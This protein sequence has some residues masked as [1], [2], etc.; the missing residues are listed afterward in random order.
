M[1]SIWNKSI[2][3]L[4]GGLA[5]LLAAF[6]LTGCITM[7]VESDFNEDGSATHSMAITIDTSQLGDL[8]E[9]FNA[10]EGFGE[11]EEGAAQEGYQV[12]NISEGDILGV[13][14]SRD[15]DD[16]EDLGQILNDL[17]NAGT[18]TGQEANPFSGAFERDGDDYRI[19]LTVDG[20][21]LNQGAGEGMS[22]GGGEDMGDL[23][24]GLDQI[25]EMTYTA[26][27]P[28]DIDAD[29]TNGTVNDDGSITWDL[30][31]SGQETL[32]AQSSSGGGDSN[33][34]LL[35]VIAGGIVL[36]LI[37]LAAVGFVVFMNRRT[38]A[39]GAPSAA[40]ASTSPATGSTWSTDP[41]QPTQQIPGQE[42]DTTLR[43]DEPT[44]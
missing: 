30:P 15:V 23:G 1:V 20:D 33:L 5:L 26:R 34:V 12:E 16:S 31:L 36:G 2:P 17:F 18:E 37:A 13:R 43:S 11:L 44:T 10:E 14:V 28:G 6:A 9:E 27:L 24:F 22:E 25:L 38:P 39:P 29:E 40:G 7:D 3:L 21:I 19:D 41:N 35:L 42:G 8:G 32:V 4:R